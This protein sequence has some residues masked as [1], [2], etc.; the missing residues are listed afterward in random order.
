MPRTQVGIIGAGPAG[1]VLALRLRQAG[2]EAVVLERRDRGQVERRVRAGV[3]DR[4]TAGVMAELG[5]DDRLRRE[6]LIHG[7]VQ[8]RFGDTGLRIDLEDLTGSRVVIYSQQEA[9]KDL[10]DAATQRGAPVVFDAEDVAL[11][12]LTDDRPRLGW[13][14]AGVARQIDCDFIVGCDGF[15]GVSRRT[16]P[17]GALRTFERVYPFAWLGMLADAPPVSRELIYAS[18]ARGFALAS[19]RTP[20]LS[21]YYLQCG[22]DERPEEWPDARFWEELGLRLGLASPPARGAILE[23]SMTPLRAFVCEPMRHGRL[24]LAGDA[25]HVSPPTGAKGLN[26][27]VSDAVL[28]SRALIEHY[29]HGSAEGLDGYSARALARVWSTL[30]FSTWLTELTH[31]P[32]DADPFG[33]ALRSAE[34]EHLRGSRAAQALLAEQYVGA[35]MDSAETDGPAAR[36][37]DDIQDPRA[38]PGTIVFTG[39]QS[40]KGAGLNRFCLSLLD[41]DNRARFKADE[42]AYLAA[43]P[44]TQA[45]RTAIMARDYNAALAE[46]GNI[47][48]LAK[49]FATDG[50]S[51]RAAAAT[52]TGMPVEAYAEMMRAGG[53]SP[54]V[55]VNPMGGT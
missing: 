1:M 23:R 3:I 51:F 53:R 38:I 55:G 9:L 31:K 47:Y 18:H 50:V 7:G 16:I 14:T 30:R 2:I 13:R 44:M 46:G 10:F 17:T 48:C 27:A 26:L 54:A 33:E 37:V 29:R 42:A 5:V 28:L 24:F 34:F 22:P 21:R 41:P 4:V 11:S 19:L 43:W 36:H 35:P 15:H 52:M 40:R 12:G 39:E 49:V 6:G 45:Q 8:F 32:P 20:R 25:A